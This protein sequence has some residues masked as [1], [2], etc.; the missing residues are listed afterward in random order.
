MNTDLIIY[1]FIGITNLLCGN[2]GRFDYALIWIVLIVNL[3]EQ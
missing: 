1:G 2:I 3:I